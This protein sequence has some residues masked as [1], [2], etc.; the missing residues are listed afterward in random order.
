MISIFAYEFNETI[1]RFNAS[2]FNIYVSNI[3][4]NNNLIKLHDNQI[5]SHKYVEALG[6][7]NANKYPN[8]ILIT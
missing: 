4:P 8:L 3:I 2:K 5:L 7:N 6:N 1:I